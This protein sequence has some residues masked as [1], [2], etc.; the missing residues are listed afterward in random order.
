MLPA[1]QPPAAA[2]PIACFHLTL[3]TK[4]ATP[5]THTHKPFSPH[6]HTLRSSVPGLLP[7][8][9]N[10]ASS[11]TTPQGAAAAAAAAG[12]QTPHMSRRTR[13]AHATPNDAADQSAR[14]ALRSGGFVSASRSTPGTVRHEQSHGR[15]ASSSRWTACPWAHVAPSLTARTKTLA[16]TRRIAT[17]GSLG[18]RLPVSLAGC[19]L[20]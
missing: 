10:A 1:F 3:V 15:P 9:D 18:L 6:R 12:T 20:A 14:F 2:S 13:P 8:M 4:S 17:L 16:M 11:S 19:F 7:A 5:R